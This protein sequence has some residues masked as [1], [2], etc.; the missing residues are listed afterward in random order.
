MRVSIKSTQEQKTFLASEKFIGLTFGIL[1]VVFS[2]P[3][4]LGFQALFVDF[5]S[6]NW[7]RVVVIASSNISSCVL[8]LTF[9]SVLVF[10]ISKLYLAIKKLFQAFWESIED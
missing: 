1:V 2:I 4:A 9:L 6:I 5:Q 8:T 3:L 7:E 10:G